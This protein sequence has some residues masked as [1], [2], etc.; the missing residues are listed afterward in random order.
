MEFVDYYAVLNLPK[1]AQIKDVRKAFDDFMENPSPDRFE[2]CTKAYGILTNPYKRARYDKTFGHLMVIE[3]SPQEYLNAIHYRLNSI[4]PYA[5]LQALIEKFKNW[6]LNKYD[7][8]WRE[9]QLANYSYLLEHNG[10]NFWLVLRFPTSA[11]LEKFAKFLLTHK[12][13]KT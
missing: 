6:I 10:E 9:A 7:F 5:S 11:D 3:A 13:I 4:Q 1:N 2:R 12:L 8:D